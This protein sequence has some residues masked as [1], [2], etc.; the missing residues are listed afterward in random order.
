MD[1]LSKDYNLNLSNQRAQTIQ[2]ALIERGVRAKQ[3]STVGKG[4]SVPLVD[5]NVCTEAMHAKN[6]YARITL[7]AQ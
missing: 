6:R 4:N 5:C 7:I 1:F 2:T 3:V